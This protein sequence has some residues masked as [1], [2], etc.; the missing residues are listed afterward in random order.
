MFNVA[1]LDGNE[2]P[3]HLLVSHSYGAKYIE[4]YSSTKRGPKIFKVT[5]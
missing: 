3:A 2:I 5:F 1:Q 4:Q